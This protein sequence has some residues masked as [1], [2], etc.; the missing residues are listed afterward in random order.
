M[1]GAKPIQPVSANRACELAAELGISVEYSQFREWA[2][3]GLL[4]EPV[5]AL[6]PLETVERLV[7]IA[8][9]RGTKRA[10]ERRVLTLGAEFREPLIPTSQ[11]K[12][13]MLELAPKIHAKAKLLRTV[14]KSLSELGGQAQALP[15]RK[16]R[17]RPPATTEEWL[18][19]LNGLDEGH[20]DSQ[21][22]GFYAWAAL[23][24]VH[25]EERLRPI[26]DEELV[27]AIAVRH[28]EMKVFIAPD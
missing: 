3:R 14:H 21:R 24:R 5:A 22:V 6:Y 8:A 7:R 19:V 25:F 23:L 4:P 28:A 18:A 13:A 9:L 16:R 27:T 15:S 26:P 12:R 20:L 1:T 10:L 17:W 2:A 11:I